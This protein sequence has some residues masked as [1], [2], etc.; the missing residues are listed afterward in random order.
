ML[1]L[2]HITFS[3]LAT[4]L[5]SLPLTPHKTS[6]G[7]IPSNAQRASVALKTS[8]SARAVRIRDP[9]Q[10][11]ALPNRHFT[12]KD[13]PL[14]LPFT[15]FRNPPSRH[16]PASKAPFFKA[17]SSL[18][19]QPFPL[20][21]HSPLNHPSLPHTTYP[22]APT[23]IPTA[24]SLPSPRRG[25][26]G[27]RV[28]WGHSSIPSLRRRPLRALRILPPDTARLGACYCWEEEEGGGGGGS[29]SGR[30]LPGLS[31]ASSVP[32]LISAHLSPDP[33]PR[34]VH[35]SFLLSLSPSV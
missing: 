24:L 35:P 19:H 6:E 15:P 27:I 34:P 33:P 3:I 32:H 13:Y 22:P 8:P 25:R 26:P 4:R 23:Q 17:P 1:S 9:A 20:K 21:S 16:L 7:Q 12:P 18:P 29:N 14:L 28:E 10:A 5:R 11:T 2:T 31:S 30:K